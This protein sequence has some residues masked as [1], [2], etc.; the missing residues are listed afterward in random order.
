MIFNRLISTLCFSLILSGLAGCGS[1]NNEY[2]RAAVRGIVLLDGEPLPE[3]IIRF[4][5]QGPDKGPKSSAE[6][7]VG[8]F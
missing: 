5:P 4:I 3:G 7:R 2:P 1:S 8:M 6:I